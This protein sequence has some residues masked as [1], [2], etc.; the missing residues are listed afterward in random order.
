MTEPKKSPIKYYWDACVFIAAI[1]GDPDELPVIEAMLNEAEK[2]DIEIYTSLF[3]TIEVAFS[4]DEK[5]SGT[6]DPQI[7]E[8]IQKLWN[9]PSP[10]KVIEIH[11]IIASKAVLLM[12]RALSDGWSLK[13]AD[14]IHLVTAEHLGVS[15]FHTY[16]DKLYKFSQLVNYSIKKPE[17]IQPLKGEE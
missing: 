15:E 17:L 13:P 7:Q 12:R 14:A 16:D 11:S 4:E 3:S 9:L 5:T 6:L 10:I 1:T 2:G 8:K